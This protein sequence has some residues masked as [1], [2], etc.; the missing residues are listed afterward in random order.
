MISFLIHRASD[1]AAMPIGQPEEEDPW[2]LEWNE[3]INRWSIQ[4]LDNTEVDDRDGLD[5]LLAFLAYLGHP[6]RIVDNGRSAAP[7]MEILDGGT[8]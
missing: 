1:P 2:R 6:V 7:T 3:S 8:Q 5:S 4:F